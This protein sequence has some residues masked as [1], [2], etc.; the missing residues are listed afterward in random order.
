MFPSQLSIYNDIVMLTCIYND[1]VMLFMFVAKKII[2]YLTQ[3]VVV[4]TSLR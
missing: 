3:I 1:D 4:L 2:T